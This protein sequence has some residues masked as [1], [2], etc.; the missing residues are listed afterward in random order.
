MGR[1][2]YDANDYRQYDAEGL[3]T[4]TDVEK[5]F[6][7]ELPQG[8][9][10]VYHQPD[11]HVEISGLGYVWRWCVKRLIL[12]WGNRTN[13]LRMTRGYQLLLPFLSGYETFL[14]DQLIGALDSGNKAQLN[15]ALS[16]CFRNRNV[17]RVIV[18]QL[19]GRFDFFWHFHQAIRYNREFSGWA[20]TGAIPIAGDFLG[21]T[22][23]PASENFVGTRDFVINGFLRHVFGPGHFWTRVLTNN[24]QSLL[25][26]DHNVTAQNLAA[27]GTGFE[28]SNRQVH[29]TYIGRGKTNHF[30]YENRLPTDESVMR[31]FIVTPL[32]TL[33]NNGEISRVTP[34]SPLGFGPTR[35]STPNL[36]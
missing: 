32:S 2:F 14:L 16:R 8:Q 18:Q 27:E 5:G 3:F 9:V 26:D 36:S 35:R 7:P 34:E 13:A 1:Q 29:G 19:Q 6:Q 24:R 17:A 12:L 20:V 22:A 21:I 30:R 25:T 10:D 28:L 33:I 11:V 15:L 31:T 4:N 23:F